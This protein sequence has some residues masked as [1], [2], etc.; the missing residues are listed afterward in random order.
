MKARSRTRNRPWWLAA[1]SLSLLGLLPLG[2]VASPEDSDFAGGSYSFL[3]VLDGSA[4]IFQTQYA[5]RQAAEINQPILVGDRLYVAR[6]SRV[7]VVLADD[8]LLRLEGDT[9]VRLEAVAGSPDGNAESTQISLLDGVLQLIVDEQALG[10]DLPRIDTGNATTYIQQPGSYVLHADRDGFTSVLVRQGYAEVVTQ[11]GSLV[12]RDGEVATVEGDRWPHSEIAE[13]GGLTALER[14]GNRLEDEARRARLDDLDPSLRYSAASL[15]GYGEWVSV[16]RRRA[17]R[18]RVGGDWRPYTYGSWSNTPAGLVWVSSEPWGWV[19]YHYGTWDY[20]RGYGWVWYPGS[21]WSPAWVYWYWGPSHV[22]WCPVGYYSHH[23]YPTYRHGFRFGVY[24]WAGGDWGVFA[25]WN[26]LPLDRL[27]HRDQARWVRPSYAL[28]REV[29]GRLPRG[30]ITTDTRGVDQD[31]LARPERAAQVLATRP[32]RGRKEAELPDVTAFVGRQP[33]PPQVER[34]VVEVKPAPNAARGWATPLDPDS[35]ASGKPA[36]IAAQTG[37]TTRPGRARTETYEVKPAPERQTTVEA[38]PNN[39]RGGAPELATKP[40]SWR[41]RPTQVQGSAGSTATVKPTETAQG[42]SAGVVRRP[43]PSASA[44]A[45]RQRD[46]GSGSSSPATEPKVESAAGSETGR[47]RIERRPAPAWQGS[48]AG[49]A[50]T[51]KP[52]PSASPYRGSTTSGSSE[53]VL[54]TRPQPVPR[55]SSGAGSPTAGSSTAGGS[56]TGSSGPKVEPYR[57]P[58]VQPSKPTTSTSS[59]GSSGSG[60]GSSASQR[61]PA[62]SGSTATAKPADAGQGSQGNRSGGRARSKPPANEEKKEGDGG[63]VR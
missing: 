29:G 14:W 43:L 56:S 5:D 25:D 36:E 27:R 38:T 19:P 50:E 54:R 46:G 37:V 59:S 44:D 11:R 26:F 58:S 47:V 62:N 41:E 3:R 52:E 21:V 32:T 53:P 20:V 7:E 16:D 49:T 42:G 45:W 22:G 9:E 24:G 31:V 18:P 2:A 40:G 10:R 61:R 28:Q 35:T 15:S 34:Q 48:G 51:A 6:D 33:L 30:L 39:G 13:A 60:S 23:Y 4:T 17:W 1:L 55:T 57:A 63:G 8:N 12:V